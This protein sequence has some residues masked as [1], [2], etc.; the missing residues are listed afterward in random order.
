MVKIVL[1]GRFHCDVLFKL[2][3][4]VPSVIIALLDFISSLALFSCTQLEVVL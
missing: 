3:K 2:I 1:A 4:F